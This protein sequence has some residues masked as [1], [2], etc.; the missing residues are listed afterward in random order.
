MR[1][2]KRRRL[3]EDEEDEA[4]HLG[5]VLDVLNGTS[6]ALP[7]PWVIAALPLQ[8]S[9]SHDAAVAFVSTAAEQ[10]DGMGRE[11]AWECCAYAS[12]FDKG[13]AVAVEVCKASSEHLEAYAVAIEEAIRTS[14]DPGSWLGHA[15]LL[16]AS[17][18]ACSTYSGTESWF[19]VV[20]MPSA[21]TAVIDAALSLSPG[22]DAVVVS[23][24]GATAF[25]PGMHESALEHNVLRITL[26]N[27]ASVGVDGVQA[28]DVGVS[29]EGGSVCG[30]ALVG[31]GVVEVRY[32]VPS[33]RLVPLTVHV[34]TLEGLEPPKTIE[35]P[36]RVLHVWIF[37]AVC[38]A[39][40]VRF[41]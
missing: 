10:L 19:T 7:L 30:Q 1:R 5:Q 36:S 11:A 6:P 12:G 13:M 8:C 9:L 3:Q 26:L 35:V 32:A 37:C 28:C 27:A 2:A 39:L 14:S 18:C 34:S 15:H 22:I 21:A 16:L 24:R 23:G 41:V 38:H 31:Q 29:I 33:H 20:P 17:P 40:C 4:G 25:K